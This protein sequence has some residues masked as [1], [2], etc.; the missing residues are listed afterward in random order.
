MP[1]VNQQIDVF[2]EAGEG[3]ARAV[4][5]RVWPINYGEC[6]TVSCNGFYRG[7]ECSGAEG[8]RIETGDTWQTIDAAIE[9][10]VRHIAEHEERPSAGMGVTT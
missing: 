5:A 3:Y 1:R 10:A 6:Y 7:H 4:V 9:F 2:A 8:L